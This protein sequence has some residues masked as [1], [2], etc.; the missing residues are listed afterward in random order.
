VE[1]SEQSLH[2]PEF[3]HSTGRHDPLLPVIG[4][5]LELAAFPRHGRTRNPVIRSIES[6]EDGGWAI[7]VDSRRS[8]STSEP[9]LDLESPNPAKMVLV[10]R[11]DRET[12]HES[13]RSDQNVGVANQSAAFSELGVDVCHLDDHFVGQ[14]EEPRSHHTGDRMR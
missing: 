2:E 8:R 7:G 9:V 3:G 5:G 1:A 13:G 11:C 4:D 14:M 6:P 10:V 12:V